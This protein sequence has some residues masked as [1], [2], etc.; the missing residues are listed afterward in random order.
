MRG[1]WIGKY[2]AE[3][4]SLRV[5]NST[6]SNGRNSDSAAVRRKEMTYMS[7]EDNAV[8]PASEAVDDL[9]V[10]W[11][12]APDTPTPEDERQS[13]VQMFYELL[14]TAESAGFTGVVMLSFGEG[15][16]RYIELGSPENNRW[17]TE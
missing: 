14:C 10:G 16:L 12:C 15:Y 1:P 3:F 9:L 6:S 7:N 4:N 2:F 17:T 5:L 11:L 13:D 8:N